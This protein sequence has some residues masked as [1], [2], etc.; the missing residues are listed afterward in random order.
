[1]NEHDRQDRQRYDDGVD[2]DVASEF[3]HD[4]H[5][6]ESVKNYQFDQEQAT[7]FRPRSHGQTIVGLPLLRALARDPLTR[8]MKPLA[9]RQC[10]VVDLLLRVSDTNNPSD[11]FASACLFFASLI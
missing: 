10:L 8:Q 9:R 11:S 4:S 1:M 7:C 6:Q 2:E 3:L 5:D